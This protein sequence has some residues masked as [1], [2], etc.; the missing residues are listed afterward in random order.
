MSKDDEKNTNMTPAPI[1]VIS[2]PAKLVP[3]YATKVGAA[4]AGNSFILSFISELTGESA[5]MIERIALDKEAIDGLIEILNTLR[6]AK[7]GK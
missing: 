4:K 3:K 7:D 1:P 6:E 2:E 5:Q